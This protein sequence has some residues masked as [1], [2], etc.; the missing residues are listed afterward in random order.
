MKSESSTSGSDTVVT[1]RM[2]IRIIALLLV[3]A[4]SSVFVLWTV[5]PVGTGSETIFAV[6]LGI[7]LMSFAMISYVHR[8]VTGGGRIGRAPLI[9]GCCF[10]LFLVLTGF[11]VWT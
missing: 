3:I 5:N 4:F 8:S 2:G 11:F 6:Y 9:A 10:M 1:E 7:D